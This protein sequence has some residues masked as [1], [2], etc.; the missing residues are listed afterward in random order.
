MKKTFLIIAVALLFTAS[1]NAQDILTDH[2]EDFHFGLKIGTNY[3]NVY[4]TEGEDFKADPKFGLA[5]GA[6]LTLPLSKYIGIQPEVLFSQKGFKA[7]GTLLGGPYGLTRTTTHLDIPLFLAIKPIESLTL[8]AGPQYSY[9]IKQRDVYTTGITTTA[10][11]TEFAN[12]NIR[13]NMLCFG[14]GADV[15][16]QNVVLGV[17]SNWDIQKNNGDGTSSTPRYKNVWYQ[18]TFG[19]RFLDK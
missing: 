12:D 10:Q 15:N 1:I 4:D 3:S 11:E 17:R 5:M 8:L 14:I 7:T 2:R 6:F 18:F 16:V 19:F 13:K 9:L